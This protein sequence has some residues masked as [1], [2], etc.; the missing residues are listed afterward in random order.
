MQ[1]AGGGD[2]IAAGGDGEKGA[3]EFGVHGGAF[4]LSDYPIAN[5]KNNR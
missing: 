1:A 4:Y 3:G 2:E 5:S